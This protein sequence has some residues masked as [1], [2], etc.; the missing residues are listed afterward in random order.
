M[1]EEEEL[2]RGNRK[3]RSRKWSE[4]AQRMGK[5]MEN[6]GMRDEHRT[7]QQEKSPCESTYDSLLIVFKLRK[8]WGESRPKLFKQGCHCS[9]WGLELARPALAEFPSCLEEYSC[10]PPSPHHAF[11]CLS[12][13]P[14]LPALPIPTFLL[15]QLSISGVI[16]ATVVKVS[17][18]AVSRQGIHD[19]SRADGVYKRCLPVSWGAKVP[20]GLEEEVAARRNANVLLSLTASV[21]GTLPSS[22][23]RNPVACPLSGSI[24]SLRS[25]LASHPPTFPSHTSCEWL[26]RPLMG[27]PKGVRSER[28]RG[29]RDDSE[30]KEPSPFPPGKSRKPVSVL[31]SPPMGCLLNTT[32]LL[33]GNLVSTFLLAQPRSLSLL[34][35][36]TKQCEGL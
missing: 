3:T 28:T 2:N 17:K 23:E 29:R 16:T 18:A 6:R 9:V 11:R 5:A 22:T 1:R 4:R 26:A 7:R 31:K 21:T 15:T 33:C 36:Q 32:N 34:K 12:E 27:A 14:L 8:I 25:V 10:I 13:L 35:G 20:R 19:S 24:P 30:G